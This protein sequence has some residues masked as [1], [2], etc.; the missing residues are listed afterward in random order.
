M[1]LLGA[2]SY[3]KESLDGWMETVESLDPTKALRASGGGMFHMPKLGLGGK[4]KQ[5]THDEGPSARFEE[6]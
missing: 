1:G 4:P 5:V 3:V 2:A 6:V